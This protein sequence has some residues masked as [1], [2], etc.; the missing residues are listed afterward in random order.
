MPASVNHEP[1]L[2]IR[3]VDTPCNIWSLP[4]ASGRPYDG[5]RAFGLPSEFPDRATIAGGSTRH[6]V[7]AAA[8]VS[9]ACRADT[10]AGIQGTSLVR[11]G[12]VWAGSQGAGTMVG[13]VYTRVAE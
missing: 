11:S 6:I 5:L 3:Q 2:E 10:P 8:V 1:L 12:R 13:A 7:L 4:R 9:G